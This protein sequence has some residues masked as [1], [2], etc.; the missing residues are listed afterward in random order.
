M[1]RG[2]NESLWRQVTEDIT[3]GMREWRQQHPKATLREI[4]TELDARLAR[5][6]ARMLED[7]ALASSAATWQEAAHLQAP[8]CPDCG[9]PLDERG[10]HPRTLLTQ[11]GQ[12]LTL[13]RCYGVCRSCG[14]GLFPPR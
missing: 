5:A 10:T 14:S 8:T 9:S 4:E 6:R 11:G 7:L 13:E 2:L 3:I 12:A 1:A